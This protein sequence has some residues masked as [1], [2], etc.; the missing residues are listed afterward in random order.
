M[1]SLA[2]SFLSGTDEQVIV[3]N[4]LGDFVK[5]NSH[6]LYPPAIQKG[7]LLHRSID[8]FADNSTIV[9]QSILIFKPIYGR[10]AG[11]IVDILYDHLLS[12]HWNSYTNIQRD[13]FIEFTYNSL[14]KYYHLVPKRAQQLIPSLVYNNWMRYYASFYGL[15]KVLSRMAT[16]TSLPQ[17]TMECIDVF[18]RNYKEL[19]LHFQEFFPELQN[20]VAQQKE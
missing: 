3:G 15:E 9:K 4:F 20:F 6:T 8:N 7:I 18:K 11:I 13:V 12:T 16:R 2:H 10:Y 1:N 5:G 17:H 14:L 19:E